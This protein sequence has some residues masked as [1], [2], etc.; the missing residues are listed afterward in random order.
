MYFMRWDEGSCISLERIK[1][2]VFHG[3]GQGTMYFDE[4]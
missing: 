3:K 1:G 4:K 2:H